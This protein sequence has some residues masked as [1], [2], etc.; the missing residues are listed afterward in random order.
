MLGLDPVA[1][2]RVIN[3]ALSGAAS[4]QRAA[5]LGAQITLEDGTGRAIALLR[6][7]NLVPPP[8]AA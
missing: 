5:T 1:T 7:R 8:E 4:S 2:T 6:K 3:D